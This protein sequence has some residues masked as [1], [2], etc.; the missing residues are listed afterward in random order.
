MA[1]ARTA[2][3]TTTGT[4]MTT[5]VGLAKCCPPRHVLE[6]EDDQGEELEMVAV[7]E[8]WVG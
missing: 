5:S 4:M 3:T 2:T 1:V 7:V 8:E 6:L